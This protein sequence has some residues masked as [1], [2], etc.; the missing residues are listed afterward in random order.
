M[1]FDGK[2]GVVTGSGSGIG[3]ATAIGFAQ[4]GG[5]VVV[6]D[7]NEETAN[8]VAAEIT[9]AGGK[10]VAIA[11]DVSKPADIVAA[12]NLARSKFGRLD[13]LHNNAFAMPP[14]WRPTRTGEIRDEN[15]D[16]TLSVGLTA[17]FRGMKAAVPAMREQKSGAIVNT[18]SISG[19]QADYGVAA[20]NTIKAGLINLTRAFA[21]EY[22]PMGIRAN[23]VCPGVIDTP[24]LGGAGRDPEMRKRIESRIPLGRMGRPED[25]AN[26]V[27]FLA[28]DLAGF[29]TGAAYVVDGGQTAHTGIPPIT[30]V[31]N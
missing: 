17:C 29:V 18:A 20:Y 30:L 10:A 15:W 27:L 19:I 8:K 7:F 31:G 3:R 1:R 14:G 9:A 23:C 12:I 21:L 2:A 11:A 28:S 13:F 26:V 4:R 6:A 24:L 16:H 25:I 5:A 22:G